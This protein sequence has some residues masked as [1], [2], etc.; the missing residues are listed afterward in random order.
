VTGSGNGNGNGNGNGVGRPELI[1]RPDHG[2]IARWLLLDAIE[3]DH[4][5]NH[6]L[7]V[8]AGAHA[9]LALA[10]TVAEAVRDA[11][12]SARRDDDD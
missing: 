3:Y 8:L 5:S 4:A 7:A 11:A 6:T 10:D 1:Q 9:T 2:E 12:L